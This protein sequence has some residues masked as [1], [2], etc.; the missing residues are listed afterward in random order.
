MGP[1]YELLHWEVVFTMLT[2]AVGLIAFASALERYFIRTATWI[3]TALFA[4]AAAGL[5]WT[6]LWA[7]LIGWA[8]FVLVV[9]LQKFY[10]PFKI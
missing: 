3:E 4:V 2:T 5:F 9:L 7:D 6:E 8:A 10:D 1:D